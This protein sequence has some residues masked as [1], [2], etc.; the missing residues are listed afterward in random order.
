MKVFKKETLP[1]PG[2]YEVFLKSTQYQSYQ[3]VMF[4][5]QY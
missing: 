1:G 2:W 4:Q 3:A 5:S